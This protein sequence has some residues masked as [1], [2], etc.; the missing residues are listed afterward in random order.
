MSHTHKNNNTELQLFL[1]LC[2]EVCRAG[3]RAL[4]ERPRVD[5][6]TRHTAGEHWL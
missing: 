1:T 4:D 6:E 5:G 2:E 3:E